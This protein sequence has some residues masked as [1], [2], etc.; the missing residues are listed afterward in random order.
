MKINKK[1]QAY[2]LLL[3]AGFAVLLWDHYSGT[4]RSAEAASE[5]NLP[6]AIEAVAADAAGSAAPS[7]APSLSI[8]RRLASLA[9][10]EP[11]DFDAPV[12]AFVPSTKWKQSKPSLTQ[13][14]ATQSAREFSKT[15]TLSAIMQSNKGGQAI[16]NGKLYHVGQLVDGVKIK[17]IKHNSVVFNDGTAD[18]EQIMDTPMSSTNISTN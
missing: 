4:P 16:I 10:N 14:Q 12:D 3:C 13:D 1:H 18:F 17:A 5:L 7:E 11:I 6:G 9:T 15:H 8:A 2:G